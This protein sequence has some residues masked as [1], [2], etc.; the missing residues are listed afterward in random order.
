MVREIYFKNFSQ[1]FFLVDPKQNIL[2]FQPVN[3]WVVPSRSLIVSFSL[4]S[5][6]IEFSTSLSVDGILLIISSSSLKEILVCFLMSFE[7]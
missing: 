4:Y 3:N 5:T 7:R 2:T 1:E 6:Q